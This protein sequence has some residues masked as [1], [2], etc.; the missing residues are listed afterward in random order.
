MTGRSS[1]SWT[2]RA[3]ESASRPGLDGPLAGRPGHDAAGGLR[4]PRR[5]DD[6]PAQPGARQAVRRVPQAH[7]RAHPAARGRAGRRAVHAGA[8]QRERPI[9]IPRGTRVTVGGSRREQRAADLRDPRARARSR[10]APTRRSSGRST[11][12]QSR[13][14]C[15]DGPRARRASPSAW[16]ARRSSRHRATRSTWSWASRRRPD[17]LDGAR[18][19]R[20]STTGG[21]SA[22]GARSTTSPT[23]AP[24][25]DV[26]LVDRTDGLITFAPAARTLQ[27][28][29]ALGE[30]PAALAGVPAARPRDPCLVPP[31]RRA[32]G[33]RQRRDADDVA[34]CRPRRDRDEPDR[35][36]RRSGGRDARERPG[37]RAPG[38]ARAQPRRH[39]PRLPA[40]GGTELRGGRPRAC[41]HTGGDLAVRA[42]WH[43]RARHRARA[44]PRCPPPRPSPP[45]S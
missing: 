14:S 2:R 13:A 24:D 22:S 28:D 3:T 37:A 17:E 38:D 34:R 16:R 31:R 40:R 36:D 7:R 8:R 15:W 29:G 45:S 21:P 19:G 32:D 6:L 39:R 41:V 43:R 33:Q 4:L 18:P 27:A 11:P 10:R 1:S 12:R 30:A 42:A 20:S 35:R 23:S 26:Y 9:E 25:R 5:H 44:F